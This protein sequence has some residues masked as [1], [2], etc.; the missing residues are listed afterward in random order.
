MLCSSGASVQCKLDDAIAQLEER[1]K[2]YTELCSLR[3]HDPSAP[4]GKERLLVEMSRSCTARY[5]MVLRHGKSGAGKGPAGAVLEWGAGDPLAPVALG[6]EW[7]GA[8]AEAT[9]MR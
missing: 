1:L 4:V 9:G 5:H 6:A 3:S 2:E 7:R 8:A